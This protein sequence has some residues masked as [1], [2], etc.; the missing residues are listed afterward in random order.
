MEIKIIDIQSDDEDFGDYL[1]FEIPE[2][3]FR[4][5]LHIQDW[6]KENDIEI[7]D[8]NFEKYHDELVGLIEKWINDNELTSFRIGTYPTWDKLP[9]CV[10]NYIYRQRFE[11]GFINP[12]D[13]SYSDEDK[14]QFYEYC[15]GFTK[16]LLDYPALSNVISLDETQV[17]IM[18]NGD[19]VI[20][21][22]SA[23]CY[24]NWWGYKV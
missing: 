20:T 2:V 17:S 6:C 24:V 21:F 3:K 23:A 4:G 15:N 14:S 11:M 22:G 16:A 19:A 18:S 13:Y 9:E 8:N 7:D 5:F 1:Q 12:E 10:T